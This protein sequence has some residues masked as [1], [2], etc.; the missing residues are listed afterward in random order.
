MKIAER[1]ADL[2]A[3]NA[4]LTAEIHE[5]QQAED[6]LRKAQDEPVQA[7]QAGGDRADVHQHRPRTQPTAGG[8]AYAVRQH[9]RFLQRGK[10][11]TA[12]TN[13]ATINELVD[14]MGAS[15]LQ[16][17]FRP[18]SDDAGQASL[19]RRWTRRC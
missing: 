2:Q 11:E 7:W 1:T 10:L 17:A 12:S 5:R 14:R 3:S 16:P 6:T 15:P 13:P 19:A 8:T 4:R 18:G 9:L